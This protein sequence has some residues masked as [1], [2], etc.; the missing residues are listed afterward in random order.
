MKFLTP[1]LPGIVKPS[2]L[3]SLDGLRAISILIVVASHLLVHQG[4]SLLVR[5][6][7]SGHLGVLFFFVISG[8]LITTLL[9]KEKYKTG[10]IS[11][12][13]F[14]LR[15]LIR[16]FP[17]AYLYL[18]VLLIVKLFFSINFDW[19]S[20][21][22][23]A[24]YI[25]N[26]VSLKNPSEFTGHYWS[27][28]VEEQFYLIFPFVQKF[29]RR[30]YGKVL[31]SCLLLVLVLKYI[32]SN[33]ANPPFLWGLIDN[34]D[35][36]LV[37]CIFAVLVF[38]DRIPFQ[39]L[40]KYKLPLHLLCIAI[41]ASTHFLKAEFLKN[42]IIALAFAIVL[43]S[44]LA[45]SKDVVFRLLNVKVM[46]QIGV[47]SY[48]IYIWQQFFT[49]SDFHVWIGKI[50]LF[51]FPVNL[52]LLGITAFLSYKYYEKPFLKFKERF[53]PGRKMLDT[54]DRIGQLTKN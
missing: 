18:L 21:L 39:L 45:P 3:P 27:L 33:A 1:G 28:A 2:H 26:L 5:I 7:G 10:T 53:K 31:V 20:L 46:T 16:I 29:T 14:Y 51:S 9:L 23:A 43:I 8:F 6:L 40:M 35:A 12:K 50:N 11:L 42:T 48:S 25:Q 30:N 47:L 15:R 41:I 32:F 4:N 54:S 52:V 36:I 34:V 13:K 19:M 24:L 22:V 49:L 44:N 37:G 38:A 17:V